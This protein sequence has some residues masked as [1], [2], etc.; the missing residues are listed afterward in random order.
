VSEANKR[1]E[2]GSHY[3][4]RTIQP[5]DY[6]SANGLDFFQG[7]IVKYVTRFREKNGIEDLKKARH[8]I[9]KLIEV[10]EGKAVFK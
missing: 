8:Y 6:I 1:Q 9:D 10:E 4:N 2:G 3:V 7:S 5:W